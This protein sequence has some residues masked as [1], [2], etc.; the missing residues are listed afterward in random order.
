[1]SREN[2][3]LM[4]ILAEIPEYLGYLKDM[5]LIDP[6]VVVDFPDKG[7]RIS[8]DANTASILNGQWSG[9]DELTDLG[10]TY[11][12]LDRLLKEEARN[13]AE[14]DHSVEDHSEFNLIR[15]KKV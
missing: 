5:F 9:A 11:R 14:I 15:P 12:E 3:N 13:T 8:A 6:V 10:I 2:E 4:N 7:V 1:M